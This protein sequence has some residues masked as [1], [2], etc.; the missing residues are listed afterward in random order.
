MDLYKK[1][2]AVFEIGTVNID[3][4]NRSTLLKYAVRS[5]FQKRR[6]AF[7]SICKEGKK[8][9]VALCKSK[10]RPTWVHNLS[11]LKTKQLRNQLKGFL[12]EL[13]ILDHPKNV[14]QKAKDKNWKLVLD[15]QDEAKTGR[16]FGDSDDESNLTRGHT[17]GGPN[18]PAPRN[19]KK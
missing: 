17:R 12:G 18:S 13:G 9:K 1:L 14:K 7:Y 2:A 10:E 16:G 5:K 4:S 3:K 11:T 15:L 6:E 8:S 19:P